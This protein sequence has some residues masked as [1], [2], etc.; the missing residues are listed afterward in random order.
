MITDIFEKPVIKLFRNIKRIWK[1]PSARTILRRG[2]RVSQQ[3][4]E[5]L[6]DTSMLAGSLPFIRYN[7]DAFHQAMMNHPEEN[8]IISQNGNVYINDMSA[9]NL[10]VSPDEAIV[11]EREA[12]MNRHLRTQ[13]NADDFGIS[14]EAMGQDGQVERVGQIHGIDISVS[15]EIH[16]HITTIDEIASGLTITHIGEIAPPEPH[17]GD[18]WFDAEEGYMKIYIARSPGGFR[19]DWVKLAVG[20]TRLKGHSIAHPA[21]VASAYNK[22]YDAQVEKYYREEMRNFRK[23]LASPKEKEV[24]RKKRRKKAEL[25]AKADVDTRRTVALRHA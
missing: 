13:I 6:R 11:A 22:L 23:F 16:Q 24:E 1:G 8:I 9:E 18:V 4:I 3:E 7:R 25:L 15:G 20:E 21:V 2:F 14:V 19:G 12:L 5:S 17:F 10:V